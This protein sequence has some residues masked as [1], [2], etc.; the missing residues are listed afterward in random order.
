MRSSSREGQHF[1]SFA[2]PSSHCSSSSEDEEDE[3]E[4]GVFSSHGSAR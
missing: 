1:A 2:L 3:D 4:D